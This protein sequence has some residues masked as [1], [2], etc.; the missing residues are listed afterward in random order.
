MEQ[1]RISDQLSDYFSKIGRKGG[2][3]WAKKLT[4]EQRKASATKASRAAAKA[5]TKKAEN[6]PRSKLVARATTPTLNFMKI[7]VFGHRMAP[8]VGLEPTTLRLTAS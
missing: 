4:P 1:D 8:Q 7:A 2:F 3:A 6:R 5:H